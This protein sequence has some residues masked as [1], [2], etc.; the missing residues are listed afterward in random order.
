MFLSQNINTTKV[1]LFLVDTIIHSTRQSLKG[2]PGN[3]TFTSQY[4]CIKVVSLFRNNVHNMTLQSKHGGFI[5]P[6][7]GIV[8]NMT[9]NSFELVFVEVL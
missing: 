8:S 7:L 2:S 9:E 6:D 4:L 3:R 1:L 5:I